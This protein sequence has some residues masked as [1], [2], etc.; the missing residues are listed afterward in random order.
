MFS[1]LALRLR[2]IKK[3]LTVAL[4][5]GALLSFSNHLSAKYVIKN[6]LALWTVGKDVENELYS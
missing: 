4:I 3:E 5:A 1:V 6:N 2:M